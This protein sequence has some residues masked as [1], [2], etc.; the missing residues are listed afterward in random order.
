MSNSVSKKDA[1][2]AVELVHFCLMQ[3]GFDPETGKIDVDRIAT[4]VSA[5][6][7]SNISIVKDIIKELEGIIGKQIP[8][9]DI[10]LKAKDK[11]MDPDKAEDIL[12]ILKKE[13]VIFAPRAG[14]IS[15]I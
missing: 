14:F 4:G 5:S 9:D 11:G 6:Q 8:V 13:G 7:R 12:D 15:R 10:L 1:E 3:I 2:K